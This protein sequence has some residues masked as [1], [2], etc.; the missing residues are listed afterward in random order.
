[1]R[2]LVMAPVG[3]RAGV[4]PASLGGELPR[5]GGYLYCDGA[6]TRAQLLAT[7]TGLA[8]RTAAVPARADLELRRRA[9]PL[10][11]AGVP[12]HDRWTS[13]SS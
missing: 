9:A 4:Q 1:M 2:H 10:P 6:V 11:A 5:V 13:D 12:R 7:G 8:V 3:G